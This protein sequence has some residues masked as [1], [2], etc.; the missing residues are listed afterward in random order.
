MR[1]FFS[2]I[3]LLNT[4]DPAGR[5]GIEKE[6]WDEFGVEMALLA[7]DM[8]QFSLHVRRFG[9]VGYLSLIRRMHVLAEPIVEQCRGTTM[10]HHADNL[11]ATF[12]EAIDAVAAAVM[13]NRTLAEEAKAGRPSFGVGIGIDF[14]RFLMIPGE[15]CFGDT[16]NIA[17]KLGED[18]A[19]TGEILITAATRARLG[20]AFA[21][22]LQEQPASV[23]GLE[24]A[25]FSVLYEEKK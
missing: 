16:V 1:D 6:L 15:D 14:G 17:Y 22:E 11:M 12:P 7:L 10:K 4:V 5:G 13:I 18:L 24:L 21:F 9:I 25:T 19:R 3:D 20:A 2:V 23:S 8:S